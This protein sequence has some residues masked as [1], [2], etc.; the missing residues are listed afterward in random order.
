MPVT[1]SPPESRDDL[2][3]GVLPCAVRW[4]DIGLLCVLAMIVFGVQSLAWPLF[5]GRDAQT[6]LMYWL[7]MGKGDPVFPQ[8]MLFRTP[9]SPILLGGTLDLGGP[10]LTELLLGA[11]YVT[12]IVA[13][14]V[15]GAFWSRWAGLLAAGAVLLYPGYGALFH[16]VSSD[17]LFAFGLLVW[18][19]FVCATTVAPSVRKFALHGV[20][21]FLLVMIR[22]SGLTLALVFPLLP[23][24]LP[25]SAGVRIARVAAFAAVAGALL[26]GWSAYNSVR[27]DDFTISRLSGAQIPL[28]RLLL[29]DHLIEPENGPATREL[30]AAIE[31]D[32]LTREPYRSYGIDLDRFLHEGRIAPWADLAGLADRTWGWEDDYRKLQA[33][34][35]EAI[36][37]HPAEFARGVGDTVID[38]LTKARY[39]PPA[40]ESPPPPRTIECELGCTGQ[41]FVEV[42]GR[43]LPAPLDEAEPIPRSHQYWLQS[44]PDDSIQSDWASLAHPGFRFDE[45]EAARRYAELR[46]DLAGLV[47]KLPSRA[48]SFTWSARLNDSLGSRLPPMAAWLV[49]G[50]LGLAIRLPRRAGLLIFLCILGLASVV[51]AALA[52]PSVAFYRLPFDPVFILFGSAGAVSGAAVLAE[53]LRPAFV[54]VL[55]GA[56][57]R[58]S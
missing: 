38:E 42:G 37:A 35:R 17:G 31:A 12:S 20:A 11:C 13:V 41:G 51:T 50:A 56:S 29:E 30:T 45:P 6:Y 28:Y 47:G 3:L 14:Y 57:E 43:R 21:I 49:L 44:T 7:E 33:V 24:L 46:A 16:N 15:V 27:Y 18:M 5:P 53:R 32:L 26:L 23:L 8:L 1:G 10:A 48:G 55:S 25:G 34:S 52:A 58:A 4:Q 39:T 36:V 2:R 9:L 40:P 19:V 54:R 22:P